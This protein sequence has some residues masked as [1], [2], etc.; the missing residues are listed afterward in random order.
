MPQATTHPPGPHLSAAALLH[1]EQ[2]LGGKGFKNKAAT[3]SDKVMT[4]I[5]F[6][7]SLESHTKAILK[8]KMILPHSLQKSKLMGEKRGHL[9]RSRNYRLPAM[10]AW[11]LLPSQSKGCPAPPSLSLSGLGGLA[12]EM[13]MMK[14]DDGVR[15]G[16]GGGRGQGARGQ[17]GSGPCSR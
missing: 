15:R 2:A 16:R 17:E 9:F 1:S 10:V 11:A 3:A 7:I 5:H 12:S 8:K 4:N 14:V 6:Q 13:E